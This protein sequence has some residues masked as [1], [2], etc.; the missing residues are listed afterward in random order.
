MTIEVFE[1]E[2][3]SSSSFDMKFISADS[4]VMEPGNCYTD[5]IDP[6]FRDRAPHIIKGPH[7]GDV[8]VIDG[9]PNPMPAAGGACAGLNLRSAEFAKLTLNDVHHGAWDPAK[10][11]IDQ[12]RDGVAAEIIYPTVGM[13]ICSLDDVEYKSACMAA[14]NRWMQ[15]FVSHAPDRLFGIG[16]TA[17]ASVDQAISDLQTIKEMGFQGVLMPTDPCTEEDDYD[18]PIFD[19]LWEAAIDLDL[20]LSFHIVTSSRDNLLK[21]YFNGRANR[22]P[23]ANTMTALMRAN[24]DVIGTFI[25]GNVF[26]RHPDLKLVCVEADAGWAPHLMQKMDHYYHERKDLDI[27]IMPRA[28][29]E[30][31]KENVYLTFQDDWIALELINHMNPRQLLWAN[32]YPHPDACWPNSQKLLAKHTEKLNAQEKAW[33]LRENVIDLYKLPL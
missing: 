12:D 16:Q 33:V 23:K 1:A 3:I 5:Y 14:Y 19:P 24:Q 17:V 10:R 11:L 9:Y 6:K 29:S 8:Y 22:G 18:S 28:P 20:P 30:Y 4:H 21:N 26:E 31:F 13:I 7:G 25:W 15:E 2:P 27:D 32:D